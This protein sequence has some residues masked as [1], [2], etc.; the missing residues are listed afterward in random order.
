M[1]AAG[2]DDAVAKEEHADAALLS[3]RSAEA[4][5]VGNA[6]P[7]GHGASVGNY[8]RREAKAPRNK[9]AGS[10]RFRDCAAAGCIRRPLRSARLPPR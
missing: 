7:A 8:V 2:I 3:P 6:R 10:S 5:A 4:R 1:V 9:G